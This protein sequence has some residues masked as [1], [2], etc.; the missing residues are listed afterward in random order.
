MAY[1][2]P[3]MLLALYLFLVRFHLVLVSLRQPEGAL[4]SSQV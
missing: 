3:L 1:D 4:E 2:F